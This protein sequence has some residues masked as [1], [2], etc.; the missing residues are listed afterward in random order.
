MIFENPGALLLLLLLAFFLSGSALLGWRAR[1]ETAE[2]FQLNLKI[3]KKSQVEK[4]L[5][6]GVLMSLLIGALASPRL[7]FSFIRDPIRSAEIALV[8]DISLSMAAKKDLVSPHRLERIKPILHEIIDSMEKMKGVKISLHGFSN[9]SRSLVPPVGIEDYSYLRESIDKVL[10]IYSVPGS[11]TGFVRTIVNVIE[12]FSSEE[13]GVKL[14]ILFSDGENSMVVESRFIEAINKAIE[15]NIRIITVGVGEI[16][17]AKVP[18]Y[19]PEGTFTGEYAKDWRGFQHLS[20]LQEE[21]LIEIATQTGGRYFYEEKRA[22]L[23]RYLENTIIEGSGEVPEEFKDYRSV[24][25]WF[26]LGALALW[27]FFSR[28]YLL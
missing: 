6:A 24:A 5:I 20:Y 25:H 2:I 18:L 15:E 19:T 4:Y 3:Q 13:E 12:K 22:E 7:P 8:V 28:R 11:G 26:I 1:K 17:G 21:V 27:V 23:I 14:I 9:I 10:G 16:E